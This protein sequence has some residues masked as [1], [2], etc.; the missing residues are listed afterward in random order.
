MRPIWLGYLKLFEENPGQRLPEVRRAEDGL[1]D[2]HS[3]V[4]WIHQQ[5]SGGNGGQEGGVHAGGATF[6]MFER[7]ATDAFLTHVSRLTWSRADG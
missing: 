6:V 5:V 1:D 7:N 4:A 3:S 2:D